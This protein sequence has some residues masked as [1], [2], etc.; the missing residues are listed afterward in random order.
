MKLRQLKTAIAVAAFTALGVGTAQAKDIYKHGSLAPG[1]SPY[2]INT[3]WANIAN[4]YV[5][6]VEVQIVATGPATRHQLLAT[7]DKMDFFMDSPITYWLMATQRGPFKKIK[8]GKELL[9][10]H[11]G[12]FAYELGPYHITTYASA[13]I[14][15]V[16]DLK[17]KKVFI[18]PPGGSATRS[19]GMILKQHSGLEV[20]KDF[21]QAKLGWGAAIQAFQDRKIDVLIMPTNYPSPAIQQ[22]S[23]TNEIYIVSLDPA[24]IDKMPVAKSIGRTQAKIPADAYGKNQKNTETVYTLGATVGLG[25]RCSMPEDVIY[26][27]TKAFWEHLDEVHAVAK[28]MP[29]TIALDERSLSGIPEPL[30]PGAKRYYDEIGAKYKLFQLK[31]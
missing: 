25:T 28:W 2:I 11:C 31:K 19:V 5:K 18:G 4:K 10:N 21:E 17:G 15:K 22:V 8:N 20:G 23:L 7:Q 27:M 9:K 3:T 6:G 30:H 24:R 1:M 26:R 14:R 16:E 29:N 12:I 13:E